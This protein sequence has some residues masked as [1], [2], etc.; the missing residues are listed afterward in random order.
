[1]ADPATF[2]TSNSVLR[3]VNIKYFWVSW[4]L[5]RGIKHWYVMFWAWVFVISWFILNFSFP[6]FVC[7]P[8]F[9]SPYLC[10]ISYDYLWTSSPCLPISL[11]QFVC[12]VSSHVS[13]PLCPGAFLVC[14]LFTFF[15]FCSSFVLAGFLPPAFWPLYIV[16]FLDDDLITKAPFLSW[17]LHTTTLKL[18]KIMKLW[19]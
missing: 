3:N 1:M 17:A 13:C 2:P 11:Y 14:T 8:A 12:S 9:F 15:Y 19:K 18:L 4:C 5:T 10:S 6:P 7:F 16:F